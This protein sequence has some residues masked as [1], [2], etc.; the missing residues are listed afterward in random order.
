MVLSYPVGSLRRHQVLAGTAVDVVKPFIYGLVMSRPMGVSALAGHRLA[1]EL[2]RVAVAERK[3]KQ[4]HWSAL[5]H[6]QPSF[7]LTVT[8]NNRMERC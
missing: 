2:A 3:R 1:G 4:H 6:V 5:K 7:S 8:S